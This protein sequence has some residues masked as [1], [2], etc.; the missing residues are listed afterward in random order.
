MQTQQAQTAR[1][2]TSAGA[3]LFTVQS[4][5]V[6]AW[7][8]HVLAHIERWVEFDGTWTTSEIREELKAGRAQLWCFHFGEIRGVWVTRIDS[9]KNVT[10]GTVWGCAGDFGE[11]KDTAI[12]MFSVIED[13]FRQSGCEFVEWIGRDGWARLFPEYRKHAT[14]F[15]K[16]L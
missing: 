7:W 13:W 15:R 12:E 8:T 5:E 6:D 11:W 10:W 2:C 16:R 9:T 3:R 14:I 4:W 1:S